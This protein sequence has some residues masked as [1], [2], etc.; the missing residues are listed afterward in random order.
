M[1]FFSYRFV[2]HVDS[3]SICSAF[4]DAFA[5]CDPRGVRKFNTEL[6]RAFGELRIDVGTE[7]SFVWLES[8]GLRIEM[9]GFVGEEIYETVIANRLLSTYIDRHRTVS[10]EVIS[11]LQSFLDGNITIPI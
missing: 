10:V 8:K 1:K 3:V 5:G 2:R 6:T 11:T 9:N 4:E 7:V